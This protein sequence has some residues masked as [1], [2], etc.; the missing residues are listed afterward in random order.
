MLN[1]SFHLL[2]RKQRLASVQVPKDVSEA[3]E[4][5]FDYL[6]CK[7]RLEAI[8]NYN[9]QFMIFVSAERAS[10]KPSS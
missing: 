6:G 7:E 2:K 9:M 3:P 8:S 10:D 5:A 1:G 4:I